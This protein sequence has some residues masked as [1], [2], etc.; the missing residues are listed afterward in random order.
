MILVQSHC[1]FAI[2]F[3]YR[4]QALNQTWTKAW[5]SSHI[6]RALGAHLNHLELRPPH[7]EAQ[8]LSVL[9]LTLY[10]YLHVLAEGDYPLSPALFCHDVIAGMCVS[11]AGEV[12]HEVLVFSDTEAILEYDESANP[13]F[14]ASRMGMTTSWVGQT[15]LTRRREVEGE[16]V[17]QARRRLEGPIPEMG[18]LCPPPEDN[19]T[20][21]FRMMEDIHTLARQRN[22][23]LI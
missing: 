22:V 15:V 4:P 12:P 2:V 8:G 23:I 1:E 21:F 13:E 19:E 7:D 18:G 17:A 14:I 9:P 3:E 16:E 20:K 11:S 10:L 5:S 6:S